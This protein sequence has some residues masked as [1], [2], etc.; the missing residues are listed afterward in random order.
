[1][2]IKHDE[3]GWDELR[4]VEYVG[5]M[6]GVGTTISVLFRVVCDLQQAVANG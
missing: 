6:R 1:M 2:R 5:T 3:G 4:S